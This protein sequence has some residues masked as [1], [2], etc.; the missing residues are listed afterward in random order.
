MNTTAK[1]NL[2]IA[3]ALFSL[4]IAGCITNPPSPA[5]SPTAHPSPIPTP[6]PSV[7]PAPSGTPY[8]QACYTNKDCPFI[9]APCLC[10]DQCPRFECIENKCVKLNKC[11]GGQPTNLEVN[12]TAAYCQQPAFNQSSNTTRETVGNVTAQLINGTTVRVFFTLQSRSPCNIAQALLYE[13][14]GEGTLE[15]NTDTNL[16]VICIQCIGELKGYTDIN[17]TTHNI[18]KLF[19]KYRHPWEGNFTLLVVDIPR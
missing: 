14:G 16:D 3:I 11:P 5:P 4:F 19:V 6:A 17:L 10:P 18:N 9:A 8:A 12:Q 7:S 13:N 1:Q 2:F 15:F